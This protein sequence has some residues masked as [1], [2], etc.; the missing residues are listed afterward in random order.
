MSIK[1]GSQPGFILL[2]PLWTCKLSFQC[3]PSRY[4]GCQLGFPPW[5]HVSYRRLVLKCAA[6]KFRIQMQQVD[7]RKSLFLGQ[8]VQRT[9]VLIISLLFVS[10]SS[11]F[12]RR[13][14]VAGRYVTVLGAQCQILIAKHLHCYIGELWSGRIFARIF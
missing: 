10:I 3:W 9:P 4:E 13:G 7:T 11:P 1:E 2:A 14:T 8:C 6:H 5:G 12:V